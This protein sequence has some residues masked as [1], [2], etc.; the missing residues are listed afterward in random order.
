M[1]ASGWQADLSALSAGRITAT[2]LQPLPTA[3]LRVVLDR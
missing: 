1:A 3:V 2:R